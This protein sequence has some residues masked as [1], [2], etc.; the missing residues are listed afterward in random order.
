[1]VG[2]GPRRVGLVPGV[3]FSLAWLQIGAANV[4]LARACAAESGSH[5]AAQSPSLKNTKGEDTIRP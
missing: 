4:T 3:F 2:N 1:M 5:V